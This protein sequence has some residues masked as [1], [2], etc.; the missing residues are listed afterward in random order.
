MLL[1][2]AYLGVTNTF[3][4]LRLLAAS[5]RDKEVEILV[6]RHQIA[7]L[8]RQLGKTRPRFFPGDRAFLAALLHRLPRDVLGQFRLLVRPE[9]VLRWHR[10]L[11]A[12]RH[13]ARSRPRRSGRP[14]TVRSIR[15]LVLRL[16]REN[17]CW[18][19][20][21]IHGELLVLG[22][23][24]AASTVW[25]ILQQAGIDPVPERA[26]TTWADFLR[27]Q[28]EA[29]LACDFFETV[30]LSGA[31]LY[32]LAVIEH[33]SRRIRILGAT[34]HPTA[35]WVAQAAKNLVMDLEDAGSRARFLIR[36]RDGKFP[37]LFD[38][39]LKD[40]G[41]EVVLSG[42]Q[43]PRMNAFMERWVLTCRREL[44]DRT[45]IWNQRHLLH[46]L[47]EFEQF[48]NA[49]RPHQGIANARPLYALPP[50]IPGSSAAS[51]LQIHRRDR[52]GGILHEYRYAALPARMRFS[53]STGLSGA[54]YQAA[55]AEFGIAVAAVPLPGGGAVRQLLARPALPARRR[56]A[57]GSAGPFPA[58]PVPSVI[59][60]SGRPGP[61]SS[62]HPLH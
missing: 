17:P 6:L 19:Y 49:H 13:A 10:D 43:M 34:P 25:E 50:P 2:L 30:T 53:A 26:S 32:V 54:H 16:A 24:T 37:G 23:R 27:S 8:Q 35:S 41:I 61:T 21:R 22:I 42:I 11:L 29:L 14:R 60:T 46:A 40:A 15:L 4:L 58:H 7:V 52:L 59:T 39:V 20:R 3:A 45:L 44:L 33:A 57:R 28:A 51:R 48:Y 9:T 1:R 47:R 31:R 55:V 5:D 18:G 38:V 56:S 36:D 12:R 62:G